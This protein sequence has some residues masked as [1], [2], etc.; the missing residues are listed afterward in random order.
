MIFNAPIISERVYSYRYV[1]ASQSGN[2]NY[3]FEQKYLTQVKGLKEIDRNLPGALR[4]PAFRR[5]CAA[6]H[7]DTFS[8][9]ECVSDLAP[10]FVQVPPCGLAGDAEFLCRFFLFKAFEID[11]TDQFNLLR[12]E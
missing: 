10:G 11:K 4:A 2:C 8:I 3:P 1:K 6:G 5:F 9:D 12:F 7:F